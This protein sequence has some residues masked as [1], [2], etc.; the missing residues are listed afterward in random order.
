M[1]RLIVPIVLVAVMV[2]ARP[3]P[4][5]R[6]ASARGVPRV[7]PTTLVSALG[8]LVGERLPMELA[9]GPSQLGWVLVATLVAAVITPPLAP[10]APLALIVVSSRRR[11]ADARSQV[12]DVRRGLPE[13]VDLLALGVGAGLTARDAVAASVEWMPPPFT[14]PFA[15]ALRRARAGES[16]VESL[17]TIVAVLGDAVRPLITVLVAAE[18][19]GAALVPA[20]E[21]ASDEARRLRRVEAEEAARRVPVLMLFPLVLCVL[22]AF[23]LLTIAPVLIGT[24]GDLQ[25]PSADP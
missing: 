4:V 19:D 6:G 13:V 5:V 23:V 15:D 20:L 17:E 24:L 12:D 11:R 7:S 9:V 22:P 2:L 10:V 18:R 25:L 1:S 21:R 3:R 8:R 16:F 14:Q